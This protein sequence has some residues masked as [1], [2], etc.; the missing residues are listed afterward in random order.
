MEFFLQYNLPLCILL[1]FY[2]FKQNN[3]LKLCVI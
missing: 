3:P 2:I 1:S